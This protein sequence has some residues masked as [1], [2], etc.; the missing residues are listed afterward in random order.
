MHNPRPRAEGGGRSLPARWVSAMARLAE[1][2]ALS[3]HGVPSFD[4][5]DDE[6]R[7]LHILPEEVAGE[8]DEAAVDP[9][10]PEWTAGNVG[11]AFPSPMTALGLELALDMMRAT[12]PMVLDF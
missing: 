10:Y 5:A 9:R 12:A 6:G 4:P 11:E 3:D 2:G 7:S 8:F 1:L